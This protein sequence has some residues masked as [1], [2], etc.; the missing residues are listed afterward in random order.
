MA[1]RQ[2]CQ[3]GIS[4]TLNPG[5]NESVAVA[6]PVVLTPEASLDILVKFGERR[7]YTLV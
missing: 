2:R 6:P 3:D 5:E 4:T 1:R 7:D